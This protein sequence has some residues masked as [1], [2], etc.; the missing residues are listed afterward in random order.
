MRIFRYLCVVTVLGILGCSADAVDPQSAG[1]SFF[2]LSVGNRWVFQS[3]RV[4]KATIPTTQLDSLVVTSRAKADGHTYYHIVGSWPGFNSGGLWVRRDSSG[5][6]VWAQSPGTDMGMLFD[7]DAAVGQ[8][9]PL[10]GGF[11]DCLKSLQL[12]DDYAVVNAPYG[13]FDGVRQLGG[14]WIDCTDVGWSADFA[15]GVGPVRWESITIAG[16]TSWLLVSATIQDDASPL[17]EG[18]RVVTGE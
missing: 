6:L 2:P 13:R 11:G 14:G 7:F 1:T 18:S 10:G 17:P 5:H 15:R 8:R 9:W 16:P 4:D 3:D 12:L